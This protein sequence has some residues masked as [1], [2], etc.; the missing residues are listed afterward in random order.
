[1][2][3]SIGSVNTIKSKDTDTI[4]GN[5]TSRSSAVRQ[6]YD[7]RFWVIHGRSYDLTDF[8]DKHPGG[9]YILLLGKG[10][11]CTELFES[12]HAMSGINGPKSMIKKYE[13]PDQPLKQELFSWEDDGFYSTLRKRV[14]DRFKGRNYKATWFVLAKIALLMSLY[15]FSWINAFYYGSF[16]FAIA[17]GIFTEM[18]GFCLM[19]DSSHNAV[20]KKPIVNYMGLLWSSWTLWNHWT[21]LQH[22]VYGHHS[23]TGIY[24]K[25]PDIHN[26]EILI[27]KHTKSKPLA[28]TKF[29][30]FYTWFLLTCLPN[31]HLGQALL[32]QITPRT[33]KKVFTTPCLDSTTAIQTHSNIVMSLSI[34]W[35]I[36]LPLYFQSWKTV[37]VIWLLN[38][39]FMGIS[40]F[41]NVAPNHDTVNTLKN[42]P[43]HN[44]ITDWGEQQVRC[45][46]NHSIGNNLLDRIVTHLW[47][48]MNFQ[49][50]HHLFPSLNHA[51]YAEVSKIVRETCKEFDIPYNCESS[52]AAAMQGFYDFIKIM[53]FIPR[54]VIPFASPTTD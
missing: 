44:K 16:I 37:L 25:D 23:Y 15:L 51:H 14:S 24:G 3:A 43:D 48:G 9:A 1:M 45:T 13:V 2:V 5:S 17:S 53:A 42:H 49:I 4:N 12:V 20:S 19:H 39:T 30:H 50:E 29:Q 28:V 52:W 31:Q 11:D 47:G 32:Y 36:I 38:Y 54:G 8:V 7:P 22:H 33:T 18:I 40:Y 41:L 26:V 10:R 46:G 35:H 21:W 6:S 27:R 34:I